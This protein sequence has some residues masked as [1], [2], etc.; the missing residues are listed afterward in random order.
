R[1]AA[2]AALGAI[3]L[4]ATALVGEGLV[5]GRVAFERDTY[6][7]YYPLY[8]WFAEQFKAGHL[9]L[10]IPQLFSGYPLYADS[11]TGML[12]PP[13]WLFFGL[14]PTPTAF[15]AL[16]LLHFVMAGAFMYAWMRVLALRRLAALLA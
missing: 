15:V 7:F 16:R 5:N 13:H 6:L 9:P 4:V 10:W 3:A 14:F 11:E 1:A 12:Y 8:Q 2:P